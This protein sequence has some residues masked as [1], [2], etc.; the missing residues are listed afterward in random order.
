MRG[1]VKGFWPGCTKGREARL[2][3]SRRAGETEGFE[4]AAGI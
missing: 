3:S 1:F 4:M 2:Y